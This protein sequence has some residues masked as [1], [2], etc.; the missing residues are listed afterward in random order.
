MEHISLLEANSLSASE[1]IA[2]ILQ[3]PNIRYSICKRL[4]PIP[5]P[6]QINPV[7]ASLFYFLKILFNI[8]LPSKVISSKCFLLSGHP[9]KPCLPYMRPSSKFCIQIHFP[10]R[11]HR[12]SIINKK[13]GYCCVGK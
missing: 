10:F 8:I 13:T 6:S 12:V 1:E 3:N 7:Y 4:S 9:T 2:G 5:I 11:K